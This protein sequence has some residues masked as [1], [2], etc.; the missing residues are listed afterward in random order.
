MSRKG[1]SPTTLGWRTY[2][3]KRITTPRPHAGRGHE[4]ILRVLR[5]GPRI[6][7]GG[8]AGSIEIYDHSAHYIDR[9]QCARKACGIPSEVVEARRAREESCIARTCAGG[10]AEAFGESIIR[11][12][13]KWTLDSAQPLGDELGSVFHGGEPA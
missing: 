8:H 11:R 2:V 13:M 10:E 5:E 1:C 9:A 6:Q 7:S 12:D 3:L 4:G